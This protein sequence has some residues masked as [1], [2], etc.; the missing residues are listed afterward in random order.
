MD[1]SIAYFSMEVAVDDRLPTY[2][3]GLG[4]LAGDHLRAAADLGLPVVAVTLLYRGGYFVQHLDDRGTQTEEPVRW[5]PADLLDPV[6]CRVVVPVDGRPVQVT[7]WRHDL[8]GATGHVVPLYFL[9][10]DL[11]GNADDDRAITERLYG[12]DLA[13]RLRQEAVLGLGGAALLD[14]LG[15]HRLRVYHM[16]EGHSALLTL[17]LADRDAGG[18]LADRDGTG[19]GDGRPRC[20]FTTHTPVP[21]GHDRFPRELVV[22]TLGDDRARLIEE[23]GGMD[24]DELNMT[25]LGMARAD[26]VN[27]VSHRHGEVSRAMFPGVPVHWITNGVHAGTWVAPAVGRLLDDAV[28]GWRLD[29][30]LLRAAVDID[31]EELRAAHAVTKRALFDEVAIRTGVRLDPSVLTVAVARRAAAYKRT[32]LLLSDPD[33]LRALVDR[34]GP[35]QIVYSGKAHPADRDGKALIERVVAVGRDLAGTIPVV[36]LEEYSMG[37]AG[38]LCAGTDL[39]I[40]TP[41]KPLEASGTS[42]MKA[43]LNGVPS[44]SVPD[45]WWVEGHV[46]GVTGWA[47]GQDTPDRDDQAEAADLYAKLELVVAPLFYD[48]PDRYAAVMRSC[49]A[50]T[51]SYFNAERMVAQYARL[52]Y[53]TGLAA[54]VVHPEYSRLR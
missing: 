21:A 41:V 36:Y 11:D 28:P 37:L 46:E 3:G 52:A 14:A 47:I 35:L 48:R 22:A 25:L 23:L 33:R 40:N 2:S 12:G 18:S 39:W 43:A 17:S 24:G 8:A 31:L 1:H 42:G 7:A 44:L 27:A 5:D 54:D 50:L 29:N 6:D 49:I 38:M 19:D 9:D 4:V 45:G 32:D 10:T 51:G 15:H 34:A 13:Y 53:R 20:V 16:N 26:F 30:A